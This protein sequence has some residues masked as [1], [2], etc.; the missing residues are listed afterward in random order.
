MVENINSSKKTFNKKEFCSGCPY[1]SDATNVVE[2]VRL[3]KEVLIVMQSPGKEE[4]KLSK[5]LSGFKKS[6]ATKIL[7]RL[8]P[9]GHVIEDYAVSELIKCRPTKRGIDKQALAV[10]YRYLEEEI[11]T[12]NYSKIICFCVDAFA[13]VQNIKERY[14]GEFDVALCKYPKNTLRKEEKNHITETLKFK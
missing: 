2:G 9:K 1:L 8:M 11:S 10:C 3:E 6:S 7:E 14:K 4:D 12:H 13:I 5:P